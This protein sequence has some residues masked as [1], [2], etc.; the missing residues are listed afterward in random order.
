MRKLKK[1]MAVLSIA[2]AFASCKQNIK[3][4]TNVTDSTETLSKE[5]VYIHNKNKNEFTLSFIQEGDSVVGK[6]S[7][8]LN[9]RDENNGT[10]KG[11]IKDNLLIADY[12]FMSEGIKSIRQV[13]FKMED[14]SLLE[15]YGDVIEKD[16]KVVFIDLTQLRYNEDFKLNLAK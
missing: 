13:V 4:E 2:I 14:D 12:D 11:V 15:G 7:Y 3:E 6:Y 9:G 5:K 10:I 1:I 8:H 16:G